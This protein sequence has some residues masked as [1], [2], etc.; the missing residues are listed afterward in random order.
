MHG[1]RSAAQGLRMSPSTDE[2]GTWLVL[3]WALMICKHPIEQHPPRLTGEWIHL[4][5]LPIALAGHSIAQPGP[6]T[7]ASQSSAC[8]DTYTP[9][10]RLLEK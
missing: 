1:E 5:L 7:V 2:T 3:P 4:H 8:D 9:V 6:T 10:L